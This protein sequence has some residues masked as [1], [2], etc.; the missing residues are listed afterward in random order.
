MDSG[1]LRNAGVAFIHD[2]NKTILQHQIDYSFPWD[3]D[4]EI[5]SIHGRV[6]ETAILIGE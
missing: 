2:A 3:I 6:S 5:A 1:H 4:D